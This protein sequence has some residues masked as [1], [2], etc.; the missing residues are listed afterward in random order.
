MPATRLFSGASFIYAKLTDILFEVKAVLC[1]L[2]DKY[3]ARNML[4]SCKIPSVKV[5]YCKK[6]YYL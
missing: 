2:R 1:F 5:Y 4:F 6:H 3:P